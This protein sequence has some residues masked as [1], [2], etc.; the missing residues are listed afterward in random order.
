MDAGSLIR[1]AWEIVPILILL[2]VGGVI[3]IRSGV[4]Q[5]TSRRDFR[6]V[7]GN[8]SQILLRV[9]AYAAAMLLVHEWIGIRPGLGW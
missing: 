2:L 1:G 7:L 8:L 6:R 9:L 4:H 5:L 3:A